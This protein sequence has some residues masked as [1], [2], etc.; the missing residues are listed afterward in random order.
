MEVY[1][2]TFTG[3]GRKEESRGLLSAMYVT[4]GILLAFGFVSISHKLYSYF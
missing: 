1:G 3:M 2:K 4:C